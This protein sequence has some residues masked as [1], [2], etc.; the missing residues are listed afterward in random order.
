MLVWL[1]SGVGA[2]AFFAI[3]LIRNA[4]ADDKRRKTTKRPLTPNNW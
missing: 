1:L 3:L 4:E 2:A